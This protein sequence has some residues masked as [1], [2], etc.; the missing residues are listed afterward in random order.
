M[1]YYVGVEGGLWYGPMGLF[2]SRQDAECAARQWLERTG[3][4]VD[5]RAYIIALD[6]DRRVSGCT[7]GGRDECPACERRK[8]YL[9]VSNG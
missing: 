2:P 9:E 1:V 7:C 6:D 3:E 4:S 5:G 8:T